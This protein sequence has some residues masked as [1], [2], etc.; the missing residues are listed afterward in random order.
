MVRLSA[1]GVRPAVLR[2]C[3][4]A[5]AV[6]TALCAA[7]PTCD[8]STTDPTARTP[9][10]R[11]VQKAQ[12]QLAPT[13][14][15][16]DLTR[17]AVENKARAEIGA[18]LDSLITLGLGPQ[19]VDAL[20][21]L[22]TVLEATPP[23]RSSRSLR[24]EATEARVPDVNV[25]YAT[26]RRAVVFVEPESQ[27]QVTLESQTA[28]QLVYAFY[29]QG[30]GGL[31][32]ALYD[33]RGRLD[34]IR[35]RTCLLEGHVRLAEILGK[36]APL[37]TLDRQGAAT[38]LDIEPTHLHATFAD[39][40]CSA[41]GRFL[42]GR[43]RDGGWPA[44]LRSV[45]NPPPTSE[46]LMHPAKVDLDFPVHVSLPNW[47]GDEYDADEPI[48]KADKIYEDVIGELTMHRLLVERGVEPTDAL[49]AVVGWDGDL[50]QIY[51]HESGEQI[52]LWR[53]AWDREVDAEQFAAAIAP[54]GIEP[55]AF[56]VERHGRV[57]D[58][59]STRTPE[60]AAKL[61][62]ILRENTGEPTAQPADG[63]STA[64]IESRLGQ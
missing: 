59:V 55:R 42:Y 11:A 10:G 44:V 60:T 38:N 18:D 64:A 16:V 53:S 36:N 9:E 5:L 15:V 39:T 4:R 6:A 33:S 29:D 51:K 8:G 1:L 25:Y 43:Y 41:G 61:H 40:L 31:S 45:R 52:I 28:G 62:A 14:V 35:V 56:R 46:Q 30:P 23:L 37:D 26:T 19:Q 17:L 58:A 22:R 47:P 2:R 49:R 32:E 24:E 57:V 50:V 27:D 48:G 20:L 12:R 63:A 21:T 7:A 13:G 3:G 34:A 54:K